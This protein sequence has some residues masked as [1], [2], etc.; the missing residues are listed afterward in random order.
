M[1]EGPLKS[2]PRV[3]FRRL[4]NSL[5]SETINLSV[6][7]SHTDCVAAEF[8]QGTSPHRATIGLSVYIEPHPTTPKTRLGPVPCMMMTGLPWRSARKYRHNRVVLAR[9]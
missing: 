2:V 6:D 7:G 4:L 9:P 8:M 1:V 3:T 5:S